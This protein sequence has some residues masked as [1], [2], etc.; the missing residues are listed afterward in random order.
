MSGPHVRGSTSIENSPP[1]LASGKRFVSVS[2]MSSSSSSVRKVG[3]PPPKWSC[4]SSWLP[5]M[6][7]FTRSHSR[8][9]LSM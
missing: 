1:S 8:P 9:M 6:L 4:S 5:V 3:V 2:I 7:A